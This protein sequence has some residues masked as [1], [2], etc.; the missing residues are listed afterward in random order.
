MR[1]LLLLLFI[2]LISCSNGTNSIKAYKT[3]VMPPVPKPIKR[4]NIALVLG[5]GGARGM[6]HLGVISVLQENNI[7]ID[8]VV[9]TSIGSVVGAI[10]ADNPNNLNLYRD[11]VDIKQ[12]DLVSFSIFSGEGGFS[13]G[14]KLESFLN[15]NLHAKTFEQLQVPFV[16]V[17]TDLANGQPFILRSG[18]IAPAVHASSAIAGFFI[19]VSIYG[20][21]LIDGGFS[22]PL[23][24]MIA[25]QF[26]PKVIIAVNIDRELSSNYNKG[27]FDIINRSIDIVVTRLSD[28]A[29]DQADVLIRPQ[30]KQ[31]GTFD[32]KNNKKLYE[33]G[34]H[35]ALEQLAKIQQIIK[36]SL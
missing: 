21:N 6:A 29:V 34:R 9:G 31:I 12:K 10:Y 5:G 28:N 16:A 27:I 20:T 25:K 7:P 13:S 3:E 35:A 19:P 22:Q 24:V 1:L 30:V 26:N 17:A 23:P 33:L 36:K 18:P 4:P 11:F 2:S 8:L 32:D 14:E 15:H